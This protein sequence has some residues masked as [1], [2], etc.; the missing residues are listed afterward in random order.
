M[1]TSFSVAEQRFIRENWGKVPVE[2]MAAQ[3]GRRSKVI[4]KWAAVN[5]ADVADIFDI[6][7]RP[8][9]KQFQK[10]LTKE[11]LEFFVYRYR[12]LVNQ[13]RE[14]LLA[15]EETQVFLLIKFEILMTRNLQERK[16]ILDEITRIEALLNVVSVKKNVNE[17]L[18]MEKIL[19]KLR[20]ASTDY[21]NEYVRLEE[22]HAAL[23]KDLKSTRDQRIKHLENAKTTFLDIIKM[24]QDD[25]IRE[26]EGRQ[27]ELVRMA[28]QKEYKR[29][30]AFYTYGDNQVDRPI[31]NGEIIEEETNNNSG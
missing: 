5:V 8:E 19:G 11:E 17:R 10:E 20:L 6:T 14:D 1:A 30:S 16:K 31:L 3:L 4:E 18:E 27:I 9:W 12:K 2:K 13:F 29:L 23:M 25:E 24:L 15:S 28:T 7:V 26:I 21:T 22:K